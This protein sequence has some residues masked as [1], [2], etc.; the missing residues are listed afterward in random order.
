[1]NYGLQSKERP[2]KL[3]G[4]VPQSEAKVTKLGPYPLT[5]RNSGENPDL[6]TPSVETKKIASRGFTFEFPG[7]SFIVIRMERK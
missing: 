3:A 1:V 5:A 2:V 6:I 4:F 7:H